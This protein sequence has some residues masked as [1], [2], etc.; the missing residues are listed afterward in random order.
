M[1]N[2]PMTISERI[3]SEDSAVVVRPIKKDTKKTGAKKTKK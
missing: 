3:K 2:K 1:A